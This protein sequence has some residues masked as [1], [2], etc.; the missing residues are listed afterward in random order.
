MKARF[1]LGRAMIALAIVFSGCSAG[2]PV[3]R[4]RALAYTHPAPINQVQDAAF[5]IH[6][7]DPAKSLILL[8]NETRGLEVHDVNGYLLKLLTEA[9][10][11]QYVDVVYGFGPQRQDLAVVSC[12]DGVRVFAIDPD[13][14]KLRDITAD[15]TIKTF[16]DIR[17][18]GLFCYTSPRTGKYYF[19]VTDGMGHVQQ[20]E[21]IASGE[22]I[23]AKMVRAFDFPGRSKGGSA[24]NE[25]GVAYLCEDKT[26]VWRIPAEPTE[27]PDVTLVIKANEHGLLPHVRGPAIYHAANGKGYLLVTSQGSKDGHTCIKVYDRQPPYRFVGTIDPSAEGLGPLDHS[28]GLDVTN[29]P[30]GPH[31]PSGVLAVNDQDTPS[32]NE[33]FKLY[34]WSDIAAA[35]HLMTD[36]KSPIRFAM[37]PR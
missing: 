8:T 19:F 31:F 11:P 29:A 35:L 14:R 32:G 16:A 25:T 15:D 24:D 6:P 26:G 33:D 34:S 1:V 28:S 17:P 9:S 5:W 22:N 2:D 21:L 10:N 13:K 3:A 20:H 12:D 37:Q 7:S 36:T 23:G 30:F 4:P 18:L 27:K